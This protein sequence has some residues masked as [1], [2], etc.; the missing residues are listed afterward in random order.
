MELVATW[1]EQREIKRAKL[2][3]LSKLARNAA[4]YITCFFVAIQ[5]LLAGFAPP[6]A[7]YGSVMLICFLIALTGRRWAPLPTGLWSLVVLGFVGDTLLFDLT[8]PAENQFLFTFSALLAAGLTVALPSAFGATVE[9]YL[10]PPAGR[11]SRRWIPIVVGMLGGGVL[12]ASAV[13]ASLQAPTVDLTAGV[14]PETL[15]NR[16]S[17]TSESTLFRE[18]EIRAKA[19]EL[20]MFRLDN[21]DGGIHSFD[22]DEFNVHAPMPLRQS[23]IAIF[24]PTEPGEYEFYCGIPGHRELGMV[25]TL[26]VEP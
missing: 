25:G 26:I 21:L 19:G 12:G 5:V 4:L 1:E 11:T 10:R 15:A 16:P 13:T 23:S 2:S 17:V 24:T 18:T 9:N 22:I 14:S 20:V 8:H 7:L 6:L 3:P